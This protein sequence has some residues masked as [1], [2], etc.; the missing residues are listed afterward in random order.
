MIYYKTLLKKMQCRKGF[1]DKDMRHLAEDF[2]LLPRSSN[3]FEACLV[4]LSVFQPLG[5]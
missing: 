1:Q 4:L 5:T 3:S 2:V